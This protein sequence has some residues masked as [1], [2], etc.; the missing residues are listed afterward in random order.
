[1]AKPALRLLALDAALVNIGYAVFNI[2]E[3]GVVEPVEGGLIQPDIEKTKQM[4][5]QEYNVARAAYIFSSLLDLITRMKPDAL[6]MELL[7]GT[8][9]AGTAKCFG[10]VTGI[11]GGVTAT[12]KIPLQ[13]VLAQNVKK[14]FTG[15]KAASKDDMLRSLIANC[16][17]FVDL[18]LPKARKGA[19]GKSAYALNGLLNEGEHIVDAFAIGYLAGQSNATQAL[20]A[21]RRS[22]GNR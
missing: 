22:L 11:M 9:N 10:I 19:R 1:M 12:S 20:F 21:M 7:A 3:P 15:N 16:P 4:D 18:F 5:D 8:Q 6:A 14:A 17:D 2:P 13:F